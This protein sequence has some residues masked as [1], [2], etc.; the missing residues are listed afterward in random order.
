MRRFVPGG[1][2]LLASWLGC[3]LASAA[4]PAPDFENSIAPL[5]VRRCLGCY[6][7]SEAK[8]SLVL[9][10]REGLLKGGESGAVVTPG[11]IDS[12]LLLEQVT[13]GEMP[14]EENGKSMQLP[15]AEIELLKSWIA[16]GA[17]WPDKRTLSPY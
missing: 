9:T 11:K 12:G 5:I 10:T 14:P 1:A 7:A 13:A 8:G 6:N 3:T 2:F 15:K 16:A 4:E 17:P